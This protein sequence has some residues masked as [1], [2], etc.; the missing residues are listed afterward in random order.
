MR[1]AL[2]GPPVERLRS[3]LRGT[4]HCCRTRTRDRPSDGS[5][6]LPP[7]DA[8]FHCAGS[9]RPAAAVRTGFRRPVSVPRLAADGPSDDDGV[10]EVEEDRKP[11]S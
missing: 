8:A 5:A 7:V 6:R 11:W 10:A 9:P 2:P 1:A 4:R 3:S